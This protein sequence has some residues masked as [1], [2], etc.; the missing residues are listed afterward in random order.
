MI[1]L[2][3]GGICLLFGVLYPAIAILIH[4]L[5]GSKKTVKEIWREL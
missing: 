1:L 4:K 5:L 2:A 3:T